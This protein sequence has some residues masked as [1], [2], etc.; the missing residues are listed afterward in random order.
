MRTNYN[1]GIRTV[2]IWTTKQSR[3]EN[4]HQSIPRSK[5]YLVTEMHTELVTHYHDA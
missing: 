4:V 3:K 5:N 1:S 2:D